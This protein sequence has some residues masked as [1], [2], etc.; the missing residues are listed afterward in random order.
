MTKLFFTSSHPRMQRSQR[1]HASWSTAMA[2]DELSFPRAIVRFAKR[3]CLTP[4]FFSCVSSS[5]SPETCCRAHGAGWSAMSSSSTVFRA[6]STFSEFVA[7]FIPGSTGLTHAAARTRAPVSTRHNLQ[8]P[9]GVS[10]CRWHDVG[11]ATPF[12]RAA[13]KTVVPAGTRTVAPSIVS[14]TIGVSVLTVAFPRGSFLRSPHTLSAPAAVFLAPS[15]RPL[16]LEPSPSL[17]PYPHSICLSRSSR[18][19]KTN[20]ARAC[21]LQHMLFH[22]RAKMFQDRLH[23]SRH[24]LPQPANRSLAHCLRQLVNQREVRSK[25]FLRHAALRPSEEQIRHLLRPDS[26]RHAFPA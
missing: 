16:A 23:W 3:D 10:F 13:S 7:T 20:A 4:A 9:T 17:W 14:S 8:T 2:S 19:R 15:F 12:I 18:S 5:Q 26:A 24:N 11:I 21:A 25:L 1:M 22:F 6:R